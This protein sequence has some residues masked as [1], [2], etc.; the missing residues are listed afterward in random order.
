MN[1]VVAEPGGDLSLEA[2]AVRDAPIETLTEQ[3]SELGLGHIQSTA[4]L[5]RVVPFETLDEAACLRG[6][7]GFVQ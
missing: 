6:R 2:A 1:V 5:G 4:V 7:E 3:D